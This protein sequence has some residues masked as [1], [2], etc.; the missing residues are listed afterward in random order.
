MLVNSGP[1]F[2]LSRKD[3]DQQAKNVHKTGGVHPRR[4]KKS[5]EPEP[6]FGMHLVQDQFN[7]SKK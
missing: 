7:W 3:G 2:G 5:P 6:K 1:M 4:G